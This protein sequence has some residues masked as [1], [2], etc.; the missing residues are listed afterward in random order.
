MKRTGK[1]ALEGFH[2]KTEWVDK[3]SDGGNWQ[4]QENFMGLHK[5]L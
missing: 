2:T 3:I 5:G 4:R 1:K